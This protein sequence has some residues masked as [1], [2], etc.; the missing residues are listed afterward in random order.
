MVEVEGQVE[1]LG[2]CKSH[3]L[4]EV[5]NTN[6]KCIHKLCLISLTKEN[7]LLCRVGDSRLADVGEIAIT[8]HLSFKPSELGQFAELNFVFQRL[9]VIIFFIFFFCL[10]LLV[11]IF[12]LD[13]ALFVIAHHQ[14]SAVFSFIS[15][16]CFAQFPH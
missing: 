1:K 4:L 3:K 10:L 2:C 14:T 12:V 6:N 8:I 7:F 5:F 16:H 15:F 11:N 13:A 9:F